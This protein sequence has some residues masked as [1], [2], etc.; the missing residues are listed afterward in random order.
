MN[1]LLTS[2]FVS[3]AVVTV[4]GQSVTENPLA[5]DDG[6]LIGHFPSSPNPVELFHITDSSKSIKHQYLP[7]SFTYKWTVSPHRRTFSPLKLVASKKPHSRGTNAPS[8]VTRNELSHHGGVTFPPG[9]FTYKIT[10]PPLGKRTFAPIETKKN[11]PTPQTDIYSW[12]PIKSVPVTKK[13]I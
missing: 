10:F 1:L 11:G 6:K 9:A 2:V 12:A 5:M 7:R 4:L 3:L 8:K 13:T